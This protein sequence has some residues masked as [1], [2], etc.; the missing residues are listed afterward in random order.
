MADGVFSPAPIQKSKYIWLKEGIVY[1]NYGTDNY[2]IGVTRGGSNFQLMR[3]IKEIN[4][5]G[6]YGPVKNMKRVTK[7]EGILDIN[8]LKITYTNLVYGLNCD[9]SDGSDKDGTYKKYT[10]RLNYEAADVLTN[11][12]YVGAKNDGTACIIFINNALNIGG[13]KFDMKEK[14]EVVCAMS[15]KGFYPYA[16]P[17]TPPVE[18]Y[19]YIPE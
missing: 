11:I 9:I 1:G 3:T 18:I 19:D 2:Q 17:T 10:F 7:C 12:A 16:S 4:F 13:L 15:Y 14:N 5:D 6:A 8:F